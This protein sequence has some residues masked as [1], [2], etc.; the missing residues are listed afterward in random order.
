MVQ[1][2]LFGDD[3]HFSVT[4]QGNVESCFK[5]CLRKTSTAKETDKA[6]KITAATGTDKT[7]IAGREADQY[8]W[9]SEVRRLI[10]QSLT[11]SA[12]E[13]RFSGSWDGQE[14]GY[15]RHKVMALRTT[16]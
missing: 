1:G 14:D 2:Q 6:W 3:E 13:I 12:M 15:R 8:V 10:E 4:S 5:H 7:K 16:K 9:L 11:K